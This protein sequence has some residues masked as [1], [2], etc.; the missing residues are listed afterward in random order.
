M[1]GGGLV[2]VIPHFYL[3]GVA[4]VSAATGEKQILRCTQDDNLE[5]S[6]PGPSCLKEGRVGS[7]L[8]EGWAMKER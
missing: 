7:I 8:K 5:R 6:T 1:V 4:T 2:E 3:V